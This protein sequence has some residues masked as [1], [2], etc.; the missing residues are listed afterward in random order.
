MPECRFK[1]V[2]PIYDKHAIPCLCIYPDAMMK[3]IDYE[4]YCIPK[5]LEFYNRSEMHKKVEQLACLDR[6]HTQSIYI[7][8]KM[9]ELS[10]EILKSE[11][12]K[13]DLN[14]IKEEMG[15]VLC[16]LFTYA[17]SKQI[18]ADDLYNHAIE[19]LDLAIFGIL[20]HGE[21]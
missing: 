8:E 3:V 18:D 12:G 10:K 19:K 1:N 21:I 14:L 5:I 11:R 16:T 7:L 15:D 20:D 6:S 4:K 17:Y 13:E 9:A 2:C